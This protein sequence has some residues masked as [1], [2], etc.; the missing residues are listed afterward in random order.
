MVL[1]DYS[2]A[3]PS[4]SIERFPAI[5]ETMG[6]PRFIVPVYRTFS[7]DNTALISRMGKRYYSSEIAR[8]VRQGGGRPHGAPLPRDGPT[9]DIDQSAWHSDS[10]YQIARMVQ[11]I[12]IL[13]GA[14]GLAL[15]V[16]EYMLLVATACKHL[17]TMIGR[18]AHLNCWSKPAAKFASRVG[19]ARQA[20]LLTLAENT[21]AFHIL[22]L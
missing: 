8:E 3:F 6:V 14:V 20:G 19:E 1:A 11:G 15:N 22:C 17:G 12:H 4:S 16:H 21:P 5:L 10:M 2:A 7:S 13:I 18:S 9:P